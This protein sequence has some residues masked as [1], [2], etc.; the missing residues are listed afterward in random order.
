MPRADYQC[1]GC[2]GV[3]HTC[4]FDSRVGAIASAPI[5]PVCEI[6]MEWIPAANFDLK[7]D[8]EGDTGGFQKFTVHRQ[9]PTREGLVQREEV[10]DSVH[11]LR[12]IEKDSE[13]RYRDGEGEPLRF[14]GYAQDASNRDVPSFGTEGTIGDRTYDS[15]ATPTKSKK[16]QLTR[17]GQQKP[18]IPLARGGGVSPLKP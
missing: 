8:G 15:G 5:C 17:H 11:K 3:I 16:I 6:F 7:S 9:V 10:I 4:T 13:Q 2:P 1:P 14:R 12:Q 18:T